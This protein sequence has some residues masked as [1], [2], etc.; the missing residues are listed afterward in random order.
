M[1]KSSNATFLDSVNRNFDRA[2]AYTDISQGILK[3]I[4]AC[5]AVYEIRFPVRIGDKIEVI[6]A[7]RAQHSHHRMPT[8]GGIR[9]N[10]NVDKEEVEA[11][12]ALMTYK[13]AIVDVPFGGAKGGVKINPKLYTEDQLE[14]ITRRYTTELIRKN[15]IG[16]GIDVPAPDYGTGPREMAWIYDTYLTFKGGDI[17]AAGCVTGK[18]VS[19][20]GIRGRNEA[21]GRGVFYGLRELCDTQDAMKKVGL[22]KGLSGKKVVIQGLGNVGSFTGSIM[23]NEGDVTIIAVSEYEG[24][25]YNEKGIHIEDLLAYRKQNGSILGFPG[26]T[27][28][29]SKEAALEL[30]CDILIPAALENQITADNASR[31]KAKIIGEAANGPI[32]ADAETMLNKAGIIIVPDMYLNAGGVTVSY[33]EWLKNLSHMR[34]GRMEKR[35]DSNT[36]SNFVGLIEKMTAK[37]I[38]ERERE[39]LTRGAD[40]IDL[41][42][43]GL[44]E[45]MVTSFQQIWATYTSK[46]DMDGLRSA[47]FVCALEKISNDYSSLGI[48][49]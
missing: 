4:K 6:E 44:E 36:Y 39:F 37:Q 20:N 3:Q 19:Q 48:F 12:A 46:K 2:A 47:A 40:E 22:D 49:P 10:E 41:V 23:Q 28:L 25:I 24:S 7:Y 26:T 38:G 42:R 29:P 45:T 27:N 5:N 33:F 13:C 8:K 11:L 15:F 21:T 32:T 17:D 9:Y 31:I 1:T 14:R 34:F 30:E 43:S 18:P 35:F 16:P